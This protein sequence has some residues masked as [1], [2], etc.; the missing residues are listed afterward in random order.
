VSPAIPTPRVLRVVALLC[1]WPLRVTLLPDLA[2]VEV[3]R[4]GPPD[5]L[6]IEL[7]K[8]TRPFPASLRYAWIQLDSA[9]GEDFI[10]CEIARDLG[11]L[12]AGNE[13]RARVML[14]ALKRAETPPSP[15]TS[16]AVSDDEDPDLRVSP[17]P[18]PLP[19]ASHLRGLVGLVRWGAQVGPFPDVSLPAFEEAIA[20]GCRLR[21]RVRRRAERKAAAS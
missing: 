10:A 13:K 21:V 20:A 7:L 18:P 6:A 11:L 19:V 17:R 15:V 2:A 1:M 3:A 16:P 12:R 14:D 5:L 8:P 4:V 9:L